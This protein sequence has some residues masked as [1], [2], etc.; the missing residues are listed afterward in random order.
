MVIL[1]DE[2]TPYVLEPEF[3]T[4]TTTSQSQS[5][6]YS[7]VTTQVDE[8]DK[9]E[10]QVADN[11]TIVEV[12]G[13]DKISSSQETELNQRELILYSVVGALLVLILGLIGGISIWCMVKR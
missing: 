5:I 9:N 2:T 1:Y 11:I 12:G 4:T 13:E 10:V 3:I 7:L 8:S 6:I